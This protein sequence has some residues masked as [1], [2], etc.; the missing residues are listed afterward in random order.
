M[1]CQNNNERFSQVEE[2]MWCFE[3]QIAQTN[4]KL[5]ELESK[6]A[7]HTHKIEGQ[8]CI[9]RL[10]SQKPLNLEQK[11]QNEQI[12]SEHASR[13]P[14]IE[15]IKAQIDILSR[16]DEVRIND[17]S[18]LT[19]RFKQTNAEMNV[20]FEESHTWRAEVFKICPNNNEW[21]SQLEELTQRV[22][23]DIQTR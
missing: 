22:K 11:A 17:L 5:R 13:T 1:I 15:G 10:E 12:E 6:T 4:A 21:C 9:A 18:A 2:L 20:K 3:T 19:Q 8:D 16:D 23:D 14:E 7:F